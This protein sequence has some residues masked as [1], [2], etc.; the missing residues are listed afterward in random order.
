MNDAHRVV[1][2]SSD[3]TVIH[4]GDQDGV[5]PPKVG[6]VLPFKLNYSALLRLMN[7]RYVE[8]HMGS[9][10]VDLTQSGIINKPT[11]TAITKDEG[12][13]VRLNP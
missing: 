3:I 10:S 12:V 5:P 8:K 9:L 4:V 7:N 13:H 11:L 1:G 2:A 6:D